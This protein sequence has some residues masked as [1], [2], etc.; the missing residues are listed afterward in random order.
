MMQE[1]RNKS[2]MNFGASIWLSHSLWYQVISGLFFFLFVEVTR[3]A[4]QARR[5]VR[6]RLSRIIKVGAIVG[7]GSPFPVYSKKM[8]QVKRPAKVSDYVPIAVEPERYEYVKSSQNNGDFGYLLLKPTGLLQSSQPSGTTEQNPKVSYPLLVYLH[9][10]GE[11][12]SGE[13]PEGV[14]QMGQTGSV[15]SILSGHCKVMKAG[16]SYS[17]DPTNLA[18]V[19]CE[20]CEISPSIFET[21]RNEFVVLA[22]R[23]NRGWRGQAVRTFVKNFLQ[24]QGD[25]RNLQ[26]TTWSSPPQYPFAQQGM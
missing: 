22:P 2:E 20:R 3:H 17:S 6:P 12:G 1:P 25:R 15:V 11:S 16:T 4:K 26:Q 14:L 7:S 18:E 19:D 5:S 9:G 8:K 24:R 21:L 13:E 23:T 10:A